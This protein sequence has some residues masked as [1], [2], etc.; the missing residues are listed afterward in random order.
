MNDKSTRRFRFSPLH[1]AGATAWAVLGILL[2]LYVVGQA[3]S[4]IRPIFPP[5]LLA[6]II[7][8]ALAPVIA[9][10]QRA[11]I[12]RT[13]GLLLVYV[14]FLS[15]VS[16]VITLMVPVIT[17]QI[18]DLAAAVPDFVASLEAI[19]LGAQAWVNDRGIELVWDPE[20]ALAGAVGSVE[21]VLGQFGRVTRLLTG[22]LSVVLTLI[23][24]PILA[25]YLLADLPRLRYS[26]V[27]LLPEPTRDRVLLVF[28]DVNR[29]IAGFVR[30]QL[31]V[32]LVVALMSW[33]ALL[34][35]GVPYALTIGLIAGLTNLVPVIGPIV[36]GIVGAAVAWTSLGSSSAVL[37]VI[38]FVIIQQIESQ[39]LF[40]KIVGRA[41]RI[42]PATGMVGVFLGAM[43]AG[44][45][46]MLLAVP[47]IAGTKAA[48]MR[49]W[50]SHLLEPAPV[51]PPSGRPPDPAGSTAGP[52]PDPPTA[53][54]PPVP[55]PGP[56]TAS[57]P[58][59]PAP[60]PPKAS[61]PAEGTQLPPP[62]PPAGA[63]Q[64]SG[65]ARSRSKPPRSADRG[66]K[67]RPDS[68]QVE[69]PEAVEPVAAQPGT[70]EPTEESR[71]L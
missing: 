20:A 32:A 68:K 24:G 19:A 49:L 52:A 23:M 71:P 40:P 38:A 60:G 13:L 21:D 43:F 37:V 58:A 50:F 36:G 51:A 10:M 11:R 6:I 16:A 2:L 34:M 59:V 70:F 69:L 12:P 46:G 42:N 57:M 3:L 1:R 4:T 67:N 39:I 47:L 31:V 55:A 64:G 56:P 14:V 15:V 33:I 45:W 27:R 62:D 5:L 25:F 66:P 22:T 53:S 17:R 18:G 61:V 54:M 29:A 30:G 63:K 35:L 7:V 48:I 65:P 8:Y 26:A 9:R 44:V 41:V 28:R